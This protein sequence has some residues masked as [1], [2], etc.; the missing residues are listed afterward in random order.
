MISLATKPELRDLLDCQQ[1]NFVIVFLF[2]R[3]E[4]S[5]AQAAIASLPTSAVMVN[6]TAEIYPTRKI[7]RQDTPTADIA[8]LPNSNASIIYAFTTAIFAMEPTTAET[9][10]TKARSFAL[11]TFA[12]TPL[13]SNATIIVAYPDIKCATVSI[14]AETDRT[15]II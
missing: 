5:N 13:D 12:I 8:L 7:A 10:P 9:S 2:S 6:E 4:P 15:K 3:M 11:T 1:N 14:I